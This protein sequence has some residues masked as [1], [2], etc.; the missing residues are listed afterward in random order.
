[1]DLSAKYIAATSAASQAT[2]NALRKLF[3]SEMWKAR[4]LCCKQ[5]AKPPTKISS[6]PNWKPILQTE[7]NNVGEI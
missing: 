3:A 6:Q 1:M 4:K 2:K 5:K 7:L